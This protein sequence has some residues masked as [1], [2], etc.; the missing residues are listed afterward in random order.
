MR[1]YLMI[2]LAAFALLSCNKERTTVDSELQSKSFKYV[3]NVAEKPSFD[4]N[5]RAV[6]ESWEAGDQ[7]FIVFDDADPSKWEDFMILTHDGEEWVVTQEPA[8][9]K[10]KDT[11]GTL[12][13]LY[14]EMP[15][16][17]LIPFFDFDALLFEAEGFGQ[18]MSGNG[19]PYTVE[20]ETLTASISLDF[21]T[22]DGMTYVQLRITDLPAS[23]KGWTLEPD[24]YLHEDENDF[25]VFLPAWLHGERMFSH[26]SLSDDV[27]GPGY[28]Y[29]MGNRDDGYYL[30]LSVQQKADDITFTITNRD[31]SD[32]YRK[33]FSRKISGKCA[34]VT[35][36]GP[37]LDAGG[38][39]TNG[40]KKVPLFGLTFADSAVEKI[41]VDNWDTNGDG[42]LTYSE[43]EAVTDLGDVFKDNKEI[44]SFDEL[45]YFTGLTSIPSG[46]FNNCE[47]L[48]S[49]IIPESVTT[50]HNTAFV[51]SGLTSIFIPA[52]VTCIEWEPFTRCI[53]LKEISVDEKNEYFDSRE[54]CNAIITKKGYSYVQGENTYTVEP[55]WLIAGCMNTVIPDGVKRI[56]CAFSGCTG[57]TSIE[58]PNSVTDLATAA[59]MSCFGLSTIVFGENVQTIG[60]VAFSSCNSLKEV[61]LP[62]SVKE[63]MMAFSSCFSLET[64]TVQE[65]VETLDYGV[66]M[67]CPKINKVILPSTVKEIYGSFITSNSMVSITISAVT[68]P[69]IESN[70][71]YSSVGLTIYVPAESVE[72]YK[73]A[74]YWSAFAESIQAIPTPG[75]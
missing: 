40:W 50:I 58:I 41:C 14:C 36:K 15:E 53:D 43:A 28:E 3:F 2:A 27:A 31:N 5:T 17:P 7:I 65:G 51:G 20:D 9:N 16:S 11:G 19:I 73:A 39:P 59:F 64:V 52:S 8:A 70:S 63:M 4:G 68:P 48:N 67:N 55:D 71:F 6:K 34:A 38:T 12:S 24:D 29:R 57:L 32:K 25:D 42:Y 22:G 66:F 23:T 10:P 26:L 1:K 37:Q 62:G 61:T 75:Y 49:V 46:A 74:E 44:T 60:P 45:Q 69:V 33:T 54:N 72:A 35:F 56:E 13:A 30:Y 18:Y 21:E 47:S